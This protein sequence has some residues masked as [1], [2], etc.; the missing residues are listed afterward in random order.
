MA[1]LEINNEIYQQLGD[2]WYTADD[3]PV[4]LL[5]AEGRLKNPWVLSTIKRMLG[6][7]RASVLD[8]GCGAGYLVADLER[9]GHLVTAIDASSESI[10]TAKRF[11]P[12]SNA[13]FHC[14]D[15]HQL[16]RFEAASF[17]VVCAMD[18]LEHVERPDLIVSAASRVLKPGGL[19]FF[20]TFNRNPL[21][22][23]IVIKGMEWFVQN[24][25]ERLHVYSMFIKPNEL[26]RWCAQAG[27]QPTQWVGI[28]PKVLS[29]QFM[30][31]LISGRVPP[32]FQFIFS[33]SLALGYAGVAERA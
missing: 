9:A 10:E 4:A 23:L 11:N 15:A 25:P 32:G 33:P 3:D 27:L 21:S 5:R 31:L 17:D 28:R 14:M 16:D 22:W 26:A 1:Q 24:T 29:R 13:E 12:H 6:D 18:F 30:K 19:F 20:H 7:R 2:R 8:I